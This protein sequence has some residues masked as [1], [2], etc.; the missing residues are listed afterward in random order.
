MSILHTWC[1]SSERSKRLTQEKIDT[2]KE[3]DLNKNFIDLGE[4]VYLYPDQEVGFH[5]IYDEELGLATSKFLSKY[6]NRE[7]ITIARGWFRS[8]GWFVFITREKE[9]CPCDTTTKTKN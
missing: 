5:V 7:I 1:N 2:Y 9:D 8:D 6:P 4:W 3:E